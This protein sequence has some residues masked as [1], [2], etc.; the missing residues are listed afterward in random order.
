M[1]SDKLILLIQAKV[2]PEHRVEL[3]ANPSRN[4]A[5]DTRRNGC[6]AFISDH[7]KGRSQHA[8]LFRG[9]LVAKRLRLPYATGIHKKVLRDDSGRPCGRTR[10]HKFVRT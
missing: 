1:P 8:G 2:L 6:G 3:P 7:A 10:C 9:L 4:P 5:A